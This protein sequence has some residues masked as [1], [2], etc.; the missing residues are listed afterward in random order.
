VAGLCPIV[1]GSGTIVVSV[2][3]G[4]VGFLASCRCWRWHIVGTVIDTAVVVG[5]LAPPSLVVPSLVVLVPLT[6]ALAPSLVVI[7]IVTGAV[8]GVVGAG[9]IAVGVFGGVIVLHHRWH[10]CRSWLCRCRCDGCWCYWR[11]HWYWCRHRW[12]LHRCRR[13]GK[14][15]L[16]GDNAVLSDNLQ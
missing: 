12:P 2:V 5:T 11:F 8:I 6:W 3:G 4:I 9:A 16:I 13:L 15:H 14:W 10:C 1:L 7:G